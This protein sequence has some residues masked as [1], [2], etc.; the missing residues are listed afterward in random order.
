MIMALLMEIWML[1]TMMMI[2]VIMMM[3]TVMI[4]GETNRHRLVGVG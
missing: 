3:M 2:G 1:M 4:T